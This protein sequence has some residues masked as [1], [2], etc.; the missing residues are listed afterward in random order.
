MRLQRSR[1]DRNLDRLLSSLLEGRVWLSRTARQALLAA[2]QAGFDSESALADFMASKA[3]FLM[4]KEILRNEYTRIAQ[5]MR[6]EEAR[7]KIL[8]LTA[9]KAGWVYRTP[10]SS[11][12]GQRVYEGEEGQGKWVYRTSTSG[13]WIYGNGR[14]I[15]AAGAA[16]QERAVE[17]HRI[18]AVQEPADSPQP[19]RGARDLFAEIQ[20]LQSSN[21][22][23]RAVAAFAL[24]Q[25]RQASAVPHLIALL[26][27]ETPIERSQGETSQWLGAGFESRTHTSPAEEA[28]KALLYIGKPAEQALAQA[29]NGSPA[30]GEK[31]R[32]A[33]GLVSQFE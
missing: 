8:S 2:A 29:V 27:D 22:R 13:G 12:A 31:A 11:G 14:N 25:R 21:P 30:A 19:K 32:W 16:P 26:G 9:G 7:A 15:G 33:L 3:Q 6:S 28:A 18:A 10:A 17:E 5:E 4:G 20:A 24:G 1:D 23:E